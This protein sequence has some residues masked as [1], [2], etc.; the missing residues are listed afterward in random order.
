M[1]FAFSIFILLCLLSVGAAS[2]ASVTKHELGSQELIGVQNDG[3]VQDA[4]FTKTRV[5]TVLFGNDDG[6]GNALV[7]GTWDFDDVGSDPFQGWTSFDD[8]VESG[9]FFGRVTAQDFL[10]HGDPCTP[11]LDGTTGQLWVGIHEDY[12]AAN[13]YIGG[14]GYENDMTQVA[15]SPAIA[16]D[17][18][19]DD[20]DISFSYFNFTEVDFDYTYI[21]VRCYDGGGELLDPDGEHEVDALTGE[22]N[23]YGNP[24]T[25]AATV[26][27]GMLP[28]STASVRLEL[29][30]LSDGGWAD[31]DGLYLTDCGPFAADNVVFT[32]GGN[33]NSYDF[34]IDE[35]GWIFERYN[36]PHT[37]MG[38]VGSEIYGGWLEE[39][40]LL[41]N[42]ALNGNA[43]EFVDEDDSPFSPPGHPIGQREVSRSGK[44][45]RGIYQPPEY[46]QTLV[47]W[48]YF[49]YLPQQRGV[50][51][52]PG[53][54]FFPYSTEINPVPHWSPRLGQDTWYWTGDDPFCI[55][56]NRNM[57]TLDGVAGDPMPAAW[58]SMQ[59]IYEVFSS[60][61]AFGLPPDPDEGNSL[62][63]P[64]ID[65]IQVKLTGSV[66]AP[67]ISINTGHQFMDSFGQN[68]PTYLE[69]SDRGNS[70]IVRD[71]GSKDDPEANDWNADTAEVIGPN[72]SA[73]DPLSQYFVELCF[74]VTH[75][76]PRQDMV[77]EYHA[78]KNRL[79]GDPESE[80]V[81]VLMD[82]TEAL[83]TASA[84]KF[85]T[86]FHENDP[87]FD[88]TY[89][90]LSEMNEILPDGIFT[91]GTQ[92]SYHYEAYWANVPDPERFA[93]PNGYWEFETLPRMTLSGDDEYS[94]QWPCML[95]IDAYNNG[96]EFFLEPTF[97]QAGIAYDKFDYL[98]TASN[99]HC[100]MMRSLCPTGPYNPGGFGNNGCT[101]E[102]LLGYRMIFMSTGLQSSGTMERSDWTL[103][104]NWLNATECDF[105]SIRRGIIF[106]GDQ[107][108]SIMSVYR[109][110]GEDLLHNMFGATLV[111]DAYREYNDDW[112]FCVYLAPA[113]NA[114][115]EVADDISVFGNGC[116]NTFNYNV[117]GVQAG[118]DGAVGNLLYENMDVPAV[119]YAQVVRSNLSY[120]FN[121]R[122]VINGF[123]SHHLSW[124]G[125]GGGECATDSSCVVNGAALSLQP[126]L[127]WITEGADAFLPW[128]YPCSDMAVDE[129][130]VAH[131]Q[132]RVN[133]LRGA[134]PNPFRNTATI[135]FNLANEGNVDFAIYDVS[136]RMVKSLGE[137]RF[138]A[139]DNTVQ[140]DGTDGNGNRVGGG[141][142]WMQMTT[143]DGFSSGK[144]MI[145]MR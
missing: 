144:K 11:M 78:W 106:D 76:G 90:D 67:A 53:F 109:P 139:G 54:R 83:G 58:D 42:C 122:S 72:V 62:G 133:Y 101:L 110:E 29:R 74:R 138:A 45:A 89:P 5:D 119:E 31:E 28:A 94:V 60:C 9:V 126:A 77:P 111:A 34:D 26:E 132:L 118:I 127:A 33:V 137:N 84:N 75:K 86:Y 39:V 129:D 92:I 103:F 3:F 8:T 35:E 6:F 143:E 113:S 23:D 130:D 65:D 15:L 21:Y 25:Y 121:W 43:L 115:F 30:F 96:G 18:A 93:Y 59:F 73:A 12:A 66:D 46:N 36:S 55:V 97:N 69:P 85:L 123:S 79:S 61:A 22:L 2:A 71:L 37:Y 82:S 134:S 95:Y 48:T 116:P 136:G 41:C 13:D 107:V 52:R 105:P 98:D 32:V 128:L 1:R 124:V 38:I 19:T 51:Y 125:C 7:G 145:V 44:V 80:I 24:L 50:S 104:G 100:P 64:V 99:W 56:N 131:S 120:P 47:T 142:F 57:T 91:P 141:I 63:T 87:G 140:W 88:A 114:E 108:G 14:M 10:D 68:F 17:P 102:Q 112:E 40:G 4:A 20:V 49:S 117:L 81:C 135:R 70:N 16:I 27:S